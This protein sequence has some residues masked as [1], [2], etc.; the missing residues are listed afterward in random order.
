MRFVLGFVFG[1][2]VGYALASVLGGA[3]RAN[4]A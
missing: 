2:G 1:L 4:E 3:G